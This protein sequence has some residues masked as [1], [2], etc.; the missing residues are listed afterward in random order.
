M[1]LSVREFTLNLTD[2]PITKKD[3]SKVALKD[4]IL[5]RDSDGKYIGYKYYLNLS[6]TDCRLSLEVFC[7][8]GKTRRMLLQYS[9]SAFEVESTELQD[10][11]HFAEQLSQTVR[12]YKPFVDGNVAGHSVVGTRRSLA[13]RDSRCLPPTPY[14]RSLR[15][16]RGE[17]QS[18]DDP[19]VGPTSGENLCDQSR[20]NSIRSPS[21]LRNAGAITEKGNEALQEDSL[22]AETSVSDLESGMVYTAKTALRHFTGITQQQRDR[23]ASEG[24]E[25]PTLRRVTRADLTRNKTGRLSEVTPSSNQRTPRRTLPVVGDL[26]EESDTSEYQV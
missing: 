2:K 20:P 7:A 1:P 15:K 22:H 8:N 26:G 5:K 17:S 21:L 25:T 14:S 4:A 16:N 10:E 12:T 13:D 6:Q 18:V 19:A 11:Q 23:C 3:G 24:Q 9:I